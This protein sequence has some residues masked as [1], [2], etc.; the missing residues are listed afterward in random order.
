ML[1]KAILSRTL[2]GDKVECIACARRCRIP[3]GS[4]GFCFVRQNKGGTLY[5]ANYGTVAAMQIDPI[6]KK[7]FNH[8][9]P[10]S[11][12]FGIGTSSCNWGCQFCQNHNISKEKEITGED[13]SPEEIVEIALR[14]NTKS[15]AFTYNEPTI[16]IEYAL[17][18]ARLAH[19]K[20]LYNL[21]VT[22]GYMT[23]EAVGEMKGLID[24]A[25]VDF[26]GNGDQKFSNKFEMVQSNEPIKESTLAMKRA[27]IHLELTDLV[28]P[29]VGESLEAC[30]ELCTWLYENMGSDIPIQF[31]R[32]H[33][34]YKMLDYP[35]TP[36]DTLKKHY[37]AAKATGLKYVYIGNVPGNR[38]EN[39]YCPGCG[40]LVIERQGLYLTGWFLDDSNKCNGC[41]YKIPIFGKP[42]KTIEHK[43]I[44]SIY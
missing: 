28:I 31:T 3:A 40:S 43:E 35:P 4:H 19:K 14:N 6:E 9:M 13:M 36:Y 44:V 26:K 34:D 27:G 30:T 10:G 21:F 20:K 15:I 33:P 22:N 2:D 1:K 7:P 32:F 24:A 23:P 18:I 11:Y 25:V 8:F 42:P 38:Y 16:F 5:L 17:D 29:R 37:D 39:T 41:G 12:V